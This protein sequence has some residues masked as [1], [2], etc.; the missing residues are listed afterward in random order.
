[1]N[2][3]EQKMDFLRDYIPKEENKN[4]IKNVSEYFS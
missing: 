2:T 4:N 3:I 1:M